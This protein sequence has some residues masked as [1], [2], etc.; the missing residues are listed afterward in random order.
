MKPFK[1][2]PL[3]DF[4]NKKNKKD[5]EKALA[6]I[7]SQLGKEYDLLIN[8][9]HVKTEDKFNSLNPSSTGEIV[10]IFQKASPD[11]ANRAIE[12]A[13]EAFRTWKDIP[14][15]KRAGYLLKAAALMRKRKHEFS[16]WMV[17]ETGKNWV[18]AD[19]DTA[20]AIDFLEFYAREAVRSEEHTSELQSPN[21]VSRMP[22]S[23]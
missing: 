1:N 18:E 15:E 17:Y 16:A 6:K 9:E 20:E 7:E 5:F 23:A 3:T 10:G 14:A 4:T 11:I 8:G 12:K 22:S 19:A 13:Y 21:E 2:E